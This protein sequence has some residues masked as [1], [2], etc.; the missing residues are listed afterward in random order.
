MIL[1]ATLYGKQSEELINIIKLAIDQNISYTVLRD[2]IYTH[3]TI[4]NHLMIYLIYD[5]HKNLGGTH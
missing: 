3:P 4:A 2:N 1:G 5:K